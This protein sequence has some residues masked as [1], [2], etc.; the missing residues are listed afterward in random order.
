MLPT[1]DES[2]YTHC[3]HAR[4]FLSCPEIN[5]LHPRS[6]RPTCEVQLLQDPAEVPHTA[7]KSCMSK[8]Q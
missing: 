4:D 2:Y 8:L 5:P 7:A 6:I 3:K 1:Y